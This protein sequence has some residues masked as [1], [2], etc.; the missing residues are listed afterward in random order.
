[1]ASGRR[2]EF[3]AIQPGAPDRAR[4][5]W[6]PGEVPDPQDRAT[7]ERS[8]LDWAELDQPRHRELLE[9]HRRLVALRKA[10]P[11]LSDPRLDRVDA[12][13]GDQFIVVRRGRAVVGANLAARARRI[14]LPY[15]VR[16]V[17]L[18]TG[19]GVTVMRDV[20]ELPAESAVVVAT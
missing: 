10:T 8:R 6:P 3:A 17:L 16:S 12:S 14:H 5:G 4:N 1:M 11:D 7:F 19:P 15:V 18:A 20:V 2:R 13:C 9:F